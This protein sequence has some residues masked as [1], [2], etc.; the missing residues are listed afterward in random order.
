MKFKTLENVSESN[1]TDYPI[2]EAQFDPDGNVMY[3][4][5]GKMMVT[6]RTLKWTINAGETIKFPEYVADILLDRAGVEDEESGRC[7]VREVDTPKEEKEE[8][9]VAVG[10]KKDFTCKYCG[11]SFKSPKALGLHLGHQHPAELTK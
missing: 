11:K 1:I 5:D 7:I 8:K 9:P 3:D 4:D 2:A 10:E 6:K